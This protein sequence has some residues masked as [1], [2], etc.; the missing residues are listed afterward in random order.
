MRYLLL[1]LAFVPAQAGYT[2]VPLRR[3]IDGDT[4]VVDLPCKDEL[5]CKKMPIRLFGL[6]TP[7]LRADCPEEKQLA[8]RAKAHL[9]AFL[10]DKQ[11]DLHDCKR[12]DFYRLICTVK[13]DDKDA[14]TELIEAGFARFYDG[15]GKRKGWCGD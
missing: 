15:R 3:V 11:I 5:A 10:Q 6:D 4:I 12:D 7:E 8:L 1:L 2:D 13:A 9:E 14:A